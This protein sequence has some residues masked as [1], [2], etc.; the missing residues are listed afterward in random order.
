MLTPEQ[1]RAVQAK[2]ENR[3][4]PPHADFSVLTPYGRRSQKQ[5]KA[6]NFNLQP[7]GRP[8]RSLDLRRLRHGNSVGGFTAPSC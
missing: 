3:G 4:E 2:V 6:R 5:M 8:L 1:V 7:F